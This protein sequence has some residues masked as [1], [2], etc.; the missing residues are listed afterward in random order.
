MDDFGSKPEHYDT[1]LS[2]GVQG[3]HFE[4]N[5]RLTLTVF[6]KKEVKLCLKRID[7]YSA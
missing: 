3:R 6:R 2:T 5:L 7:A 4:I 1:E